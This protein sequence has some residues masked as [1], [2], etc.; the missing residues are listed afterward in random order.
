MSNFPFG[1]HLIS[2][3][4]NGPFL[5]PFSDRRLPLSDKGINMLNSR[6]YCDKID[7]A[8]GYQLED[9]YNEN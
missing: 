4:K 1:F 9:I 7:D 5:I 6:Y 2:F 3:P 8:S